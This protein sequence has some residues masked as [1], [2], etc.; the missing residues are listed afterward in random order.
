MLTLEHMR[1]KILHPLYLLP[2]SLCFIFT[3]RAQADPSQQTF[4]IDRLTYPG[5]QDK[6]FV[7]K[8]PPGSELTERGRNIRG[9]YLPVGKLVH[10]KPKQLVRLV[11]RIGA[12]AVIMDI[13]DDR[14]R[15]TFSKKIP[16]ADRPPHGIVPRMAK[17]VRAMKEADIYLIGRLVCFKDNLIH[18]QLPGVAIR[19][20]RTAKV[21]RDKAGSAW[22]DPFSLEAHQ[23]ISSIAQAAETFG[24]DEIQL[25]YVR[26]PVDRQAK[27]ARY[28]NKEKNLVRYEAIALLLA[29]VDRRISLPLS[30][31]VFGLTA[32]RIGDPQG[33][34][35]SL[36][37]LA[38]FIDAISPM[39]YLA[40]WPKEKRENASPKMTYETVHGAIKKIQVRLGS[41]VAVRPLLQGFRYRATNFG[42]GFIVTQ[43]DAAVTAESAGY[44]FWN[45]SGSY[46]SVA[47][48]W[49]RMASAEATV[50]VKARKTAESDAPAKQEKIPEQAALKTDGTP[51]T[52]EPSKPQETEAANPCEADRTPEQQNKTRPVQEKQPPAL[53]APLESNDSLSSC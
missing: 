7:P 3:A 14:G 13:K 48:A 25:D 49:H 5:V 30:I 18:R 44:L 36:E 8:E 39:L 19:D 43:I 33:L 10:W 28:T 24:F 51:E 31:D 34:G 45:Q 20:K 40:N 15:V 12:D 9:I 46:Q 38:P 6:M 22:M 4:A 23:Y 11:K 52:V 32:N 26:F 41:A 47:L 29:R 21:W 16:F 1:L 27:Y 53:N 37:H 50:P 17:I 35:Q 2:F 42:V